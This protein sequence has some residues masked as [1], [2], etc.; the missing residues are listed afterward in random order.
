MSTSASPQPDSPIEPPAGNPAAPRYDPKAL[1]AADVT[2]PAYPGDGREKLNRW[3]RR[4]ARIRA[5]IERNRA[6][7]PQIPTWV[8]ALVLVAIVVTFALILIY[9][10]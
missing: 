5:E 9:A 6:G 4:T 10:S 8:L 3:E 2:R 7:N 1:K